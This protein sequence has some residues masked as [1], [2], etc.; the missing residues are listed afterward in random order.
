M[1]NQMDREF[2]QLEHDLEWGNISTKEYNA[3]AR[4][5]EQEYKCEAE[6]AAA[7]AYENEMRNWY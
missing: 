7:E 4:E 1:K 6:G 5:I 3:A 2:E